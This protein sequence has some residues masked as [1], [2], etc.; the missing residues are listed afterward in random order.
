MTIFINSDSSKGG[1]GKTMVAT[2]LASYLATSRD[3]LKIGLIDLDQQQTA[4]GLYRIQQKKGIETHF[5]PISEDDDFSKYNVVI[6]DHPPDLNRK[7]I[8]NF[9][10]SPIKPSYNSVQSFFKYE[11]TIDTEKV[12]IYKLLNQVRNHPDHKKIVQS[13]EF[14][15][16]KHLSNSICYYKMENEHKTIF[17]KPSKKFF[18]LELARKQF[19]DMVEFALNHYKNFER[20]K[21]KKRELE[22]PANLDFADNADNATEKQGVNNN[23]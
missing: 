7:P 2:T 4:T 6:V 19:A 8:G 10:I 1:D 12:F 17:H 23:E 13:P 16:N 3:N 22:Q 18:G 14:K 5:T 9:V 11:S 15:F 21:T 20:M